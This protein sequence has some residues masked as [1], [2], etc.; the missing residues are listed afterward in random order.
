MKL[1]NKIALITL[2]ALTLSACGGSA[3]LADLPV[4]DKPQ[5]Q[6]PYTYL[7]AAPV[8]TFER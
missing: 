4:R 7:Q 5:A 1:N 6:S 2:T 3:N 8:A